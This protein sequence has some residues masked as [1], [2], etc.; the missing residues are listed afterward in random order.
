MRDAVEENEPPAPVVVRVLGPGTEVAN[1][2]GG[3]EAVE[4]FRRS[5]G[6]RDHGRHLPAQVYIRFQAAESEK[7]WVISGTRDG[8]HFAAPRSITSCGDG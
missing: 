4:K 5:R 8:I 2:A 6:E 7:G 1:A 3:A